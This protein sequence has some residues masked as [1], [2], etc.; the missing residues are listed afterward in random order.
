MKR[1]TTLMMVTA[2]LAGLAAWAAPTKWQAL[3]VSKEA[4][5]A[6]L[7]GV[8]YT[9]D[10]N[11]ADVYIAYMTKD[12]EIAKLDWYKA[13]RNVKITE[14][15]DAAEKKAVAAAVVAAGPDLDKL[16]EASQMKDFKLWGPHYKVDP[17][18]HWALWEIPNFLPMRQLCKLMVAR[19]G[20][21]E[22]AGKKAEAREQLLAV[23]RIGNHFEDS[24]MLIGYA[25]GLSFKQIGAKGMSDFHERQGNQDGVRAWTLY[26]DFT[27]ARAPAAMQ[28]VHALFGESDVYATSLLLDQDLPQ[29]A[30]LEAAVQ[31][32]YCTKDRTSFLKCIAMGTPDWLVETENK[33]AAQDPDLK[34]FIENIQAHPAREELWRALKDL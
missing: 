5:R 27:R 22:A 10:G 31:L 13:I 18:Q 20:E 11:A 2:L 21:L 15:A 9:K 16:Y 26:H 23:V 24:P 6:K 25:I 12:P 1:L 33:L 19:A 34:P 29:C 7:M 3:S 8:E 28:F 4:E 17:E 32:H 30:R 14:P